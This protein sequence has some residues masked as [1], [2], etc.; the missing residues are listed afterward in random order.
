MVTSRGVHTESEVLGLLGRSHTLD[1]LAVPKNLGTVVKVDW[2]SEAIVVIGSRRNVYEGVESDVFIGSFAAD[3]LIRDLA[4]VLHDLLTI[5][6]GRLSIIERRVELGLVLNGVLVKV[7]C[8]DI[9]R[10]ISER[11]GPDVLLLFNIFIIILKVFLLD[12]L[13]PDGK[14]SDYFCSVSGLLV[15]ALVFLNSDV[16]AVGLEVFVSKGSG[17]TT[18]SCLHGGKD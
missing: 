9:D 18:I 10:C 4:H 8:S 3:G 5:T 6:S 14:I 11:E 15:F 7:A 12:G 16:D 13:I 2:K 17:I 1:D